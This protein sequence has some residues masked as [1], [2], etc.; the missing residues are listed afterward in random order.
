MLTLGIT[1][2]V[3][4]GKSTVIAYLSGLVPSRV[5]YADNAA[6][7]LYLPGGSCYEALL[8]ILG[9]EPGLVLEDGRI[10]TRVMSRM[11]FTDDSLLGRVNG[12]LHPAVYDHIA[13]EIR[14]EREEGTAELF[15]VEA[16]LLIECGYRK[17]LDSIW[18]V[19][20]DDAVRRQR[21]KDSRGYSD[22]RIDSIMDKQ[23]SEEKFRL[24]CDAVIDN[25]KDADYTQRMIREALSALRTDKGF[26]DHAI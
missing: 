15:I 5:I 1:G 3:G 24:A 17:I 2:G 4:C 13:A 25:S 8:G 23:L 16:A 9:N 11:I 22:A 7:E 20:C 26:T 12:L 18:Y 10:D 19:Y 6:K 21:L 14:K